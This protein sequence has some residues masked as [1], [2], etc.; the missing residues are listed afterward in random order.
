MS[1]AGGRGRGRRKVGRRAVGCGDVSMLAP[2]A[3]EAGAT[4]RPGDP[5]RGLERALGQGVGTEG[6]A[7]RKPAAGDLGAPSGWDQGPMSRAVLQAQGL[8]ASSQGVGWGAAPAVPEAVIPRSRLAWE[9][10][11][12]SAGKD[13]AVGG[14]MRK[15]PGSCQALDLSPWTTSLGTRG[16]GGGHRPVQRVPSPARGHL[17]RQAKLAGGRGARGGGEEAAQAPGGGSQVHQTAGC[18]GEGLGADVGSAGSCGRPGA[19]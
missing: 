11:P 9:G 2:Y 16:Q 15:G 12:E 10:G 14:G 13:G 18:G 4:A 8:P 6:W 5:Q 1:Q 19:G 7:A 3:V 17:V